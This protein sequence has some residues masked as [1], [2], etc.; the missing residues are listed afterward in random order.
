MERPVAASAWRFGQLLFTGPADILAC[1]AETARGSGITP[2]HVDYDRLEKDAF[3]LA[4]R[5]PPAR[6]SLSVEGCRILARQ[7]REKVQAHHARAAALAGRS[8]AWEA[9]QA[10]AASQACPFDLHALVP[11]PET[12]LQLGRGHPAAAAWLA[13]NWGVSELRRIARQETVGKRRP[14]APAKTGYAFF[15]LGGHAPAAA[16]AQL[17]SRWPALRFALRP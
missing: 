9:C 5:E 13:A 16:V 12:I 14:A 10:G 17:A 8:R 7:F 15:A 4:I 1:F 2:W 6:R 11:V 3:H